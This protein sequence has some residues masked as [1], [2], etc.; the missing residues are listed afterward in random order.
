MQRYRCL[1]IFSLPFISI[2]ILL[3]SSAANCTAPD[4]SLAG[5]SIMALSPQDGI[6]VL[7]NSDGELLTLELGDILESLPLR[8]QSVMDNFLIFQDEQ[9]ELSRVY[10]YKST[11]GKPARV[12]RLSNEIPEDLSK[13]V[14]VL[15]TFTSKAVSDEPANDL[16][17]NSKRSIA[18]NEVP[19]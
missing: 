6:A 14:L 4:E 5:Y 11:A 3:L 10:L 8:L 19:R 15:E 13:P 2:L 9:S 17:Q 18:P 12:Q 7:K 16:N 1:S